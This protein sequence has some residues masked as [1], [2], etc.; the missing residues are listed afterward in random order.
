MQVIL[1]EK[2]SNL[3]GLGEQVNVRSGFG[4]NFLIPQGKAVPATAENIKMY[5]ERRAELEQKAKDKLQGAEKRAAALVALERVSVKHRA[6]EESKLYGSV[7]TAEIAK[8]LTDAGVE[9]EKKEVLLPN[10]SIHFLGEHD[11]DIQFH[12]D[13]KVAIKLVV[14]PEE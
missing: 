2:I 13:V 11:V 5:E 14:E 10:G 7:G 12:T 3:G 8:A 9:V 6:G 4:R 1:L